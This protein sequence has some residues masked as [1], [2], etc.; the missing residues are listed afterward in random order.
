MKS[1]F[2]IVNLLLMAVFLGCFHVR[3]KIEVGYIFHESTD[4]TEY[5]KSGSNEIPIRFSI[6]SNKKALYSLHS[7]K[8]SILYPNSNGESIFIIGYFDRLKKE[9]HLENWYISIPFKEYRIADETELPHKVEIVERQKLK[10]E[11][12]SMMPK[13]DP[14]NPD[15]KPSDYT[16]DKEG[17]H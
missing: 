1:T 3:E 16:R 17:T 14:N 10:I 12:F 15:F 11:D 5:I 7:L 9:F 6:K 8:P 2:V 13:F 4:H